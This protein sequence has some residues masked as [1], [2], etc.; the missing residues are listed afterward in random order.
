MLANLREVLNQV[1]NKNRAV[2]GF[3]VFGYED[4]SAVIKAA[5]ALNAPVIL[6]T[7]KVAA[8]HMPIE[9]YGVLFLAMA[10]DAKVPVCIHLDHATDI[11][12]I[13]RAIDSGFTSVMYDGSQLPLEENIKNTKEVIALA[14]A[15]NVSVEAEI[16]A[17]GY[18]G[19]EG[20]K[21]AYTEPEEAKYFAD[22]TG[23]D[24]LAVA[25]G[26]LHRMQK[27]EANLQFHRLEAIQSL[28]DVPLV[29]HGS[30]GIK[31]EDLKKLIT[32]NVGKVNIGTALRMAFG[33]TLRE[34]MEKNPKEFD[35]IA[36]FKKPM[37]KVEEEAKNKI[38][39]LGF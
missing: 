9:Y 11:E 39:L 4:A 3:N 28:T 38:Q 18:S 23:V 32:Y 26:T 22:A 27:Q 14:H 2:A 16:G 13:K 29:I 8:A 25:V 34:E 6:M 24:A 15:K 33:N 19:V 21:E 7:N 37:E 5:E 31:D 10:K 17:V 12:L 20:Y 35:R 1:K 36:L 30:T